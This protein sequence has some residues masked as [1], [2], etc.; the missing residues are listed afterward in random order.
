MGLLEA[1]FF[2]SSSSSV[3]LRWRWCRRQR[4]HD[5]RPVHLL[6]QLWGRGVWQLCAWL[7]RLPGLCRW[8]GWIPLCPPVKDGW[9]NPWVHE[10]CWEICC[11]WFPWAPFGLFSWLR[12]VKI[13]ILTQFPVK[14]HRWDICVDFYL[15]SHLPINRR[16]GI[17][18]WKPTGRHL[19]HLHLV[20]SLA[21]WHR[22][23]LVFK[24]F[25]VS[26]PQPASAQGKARMETCATRC[27]VSACV[28]QGWWANSVTTVPLDSGSPSAQVSLKK[29]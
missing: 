18:F 7:L 2:F 20:D 9:M 16:S 19:N 8:V 29:T 22:C 23:R 26:C 4:V 17:G 12:R 13:F 11:R 6:S 3:C 27:R 1:L 5:K 28:S 14:S 15:G 24:G 10:R 21:Q 25:L